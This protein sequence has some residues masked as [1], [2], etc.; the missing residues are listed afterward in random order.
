MIR[1]T[2]VKVIVVLILITVSVSGGCG[3]SG[4]VDIEDSYSYMGA[5]SSNKMSVY[6][7]NDNI[8]HMFIPDENTDIILCNKADCIH[9]SYNENSNSDPVCDAA[10]NGELTDCCLP[11]LT[12]DNIYLFGK[13]NMSEGVVYRENLDGSGRV[14]LYTLDYQVNT[15]S[16]V[17]VI[18]NY[19]YV[20][21][22]IPIVEESESTGG[23]FTNKFQTVI[24]GVNLENGSVTELSPVSE[25]EKEYSNMYILGVTDTGIYIGYRNGIEEV[26]SR[27]YLY[28]IREDK[29]EL[30]FDE[31]ELAGVM[32]VGTTEKA[33]CVADNNT[34]EA[35]EISYKDKTRV[36]IYKPETSNI[37]YNVFHNRW[38][39]GDMD[40]ETSGYIDGDRLIILDNVAAIQAVLGDYI[41]VIEDD[42]ARRV[43][44]GDSVFSDKQDILL[45]IGQ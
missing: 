25:E 12:E 24:I 41:D 10:L 39:I 40:K 30:L 43:I 27:V 44:Y 28:D 34:M 35:Y 14:E 17:Y 16:K 23:T 21:A 20:E 4:E 42:N 45:E 2:C 36:S 37:I 13:K 29:T 26:G 6:I 7:A 19:A 22:S 3:S 9:E 32:V 33:L 1:K 15:Y 31:N 18:G 8:I 38:I 5:A 11:V